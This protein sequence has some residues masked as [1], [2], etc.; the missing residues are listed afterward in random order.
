MA[1]VVIPKRVAKKKIRPR[2]VLTL[3]YMIGDA[4]GDTLEQMD[5]KIGNRNI[6]RFVKILRKLKGN[7]SRWCIILDE[8]SMKRVLKERQITKEEFD[9]IMPLM[10]EEY[11]DE[12]GNEIHGSGEFSDVISCRTGYDFLK[13][14]DV[15]LKYLDKNGD[16]FPTKFVKD[17]K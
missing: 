17:K 10:F 8:S 6:E 7:K 1:I 16:F 3:E 14:Q 9:F 5:V 12:M 13:F 2:Y 15:T 4:D 11:E